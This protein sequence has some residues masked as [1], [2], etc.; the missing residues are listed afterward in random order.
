MSERDGFKIVSILDTSQ[1]T[2]VTEAG[3]A[4][5]DAQEAIAAAKVL[6]NT[7]HGAYKRW[8]MEKVC[9]AHM[10]PPIG[11]ACWDAVASQPGTAGTEHPGMHA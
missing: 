9:T 5:V 7:A 11:Q 2:K 8:R 1:T 6:R 3:A 10:S 4:V